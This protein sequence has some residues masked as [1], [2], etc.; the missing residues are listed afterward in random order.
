MDEINRVFQHYKG[1]VYD[2]QTPIKH[3][4]GAEVDERLRTLGASYNGRA[5]DASDVLYGIALAV[6]PLKG[7][8]GAKTAEISATEVSF[9]DDMAASAAQAIKNV[10]PGKGPGYGTRV[11]TDFA[12]LNKSK[13]YLTEQSYLN[14]RPVPYG[15]KGSVRIDAAKGTAD[16][17]QCV[18]DL[19]TGGA[20]LT[21]A[22]IQ[23]LLNHLPQGTTIFEVR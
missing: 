5:E 12:G 23:E 19:K 1:T 22:R 14:G 15:T 21:P 17:P 16:N 4:L 3:N 18:C 20:T 11:H 6:T 8:T 7:M 10:G 13:G 2:Q 9:A